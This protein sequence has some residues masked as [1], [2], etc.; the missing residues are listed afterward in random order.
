MSELKQL[1]KVIWNSRVVSQSP[2]IKPDGR[3]F[4]M[5]T[6][7]F[8][9]VLKEKL[10]DTKPIQ[11]LCEGKHISFKPVG[12]LSTKGLLS[13]DKQSIAYKDGLG[14]GVSLEVRV[15]QSHWKKLIKIDALPALAASDEYL[16][17]KF[18][19]ETDFAIPERENNKPRIKL[20]DNSC[21]EVAQA[22]DSSIP[23]QDKETGEVSENKITAKSFFKSEGGRLYFV[24]Q[25]PAAWLKSAVYPVYSDVDITYG[26]AS[27]FESGTTV[28]SACC[29]IDTNKFVVAFADVSDG[30]AG[31]ARVATVSGTTITWGTTSEFCSDVSIGFK[32]D[33]CKLDTDKFVVVY[34]DD[35]AGD[36]GFARV[37]TVATR[38]IS[39]GTAK[40]FETGDTEYPTCCQLGTDKF[41]V[42][43]D[44][45]TAGD[46]ATACVCTVSGTTIAAGTPVEW[47]VST[48]TYLYPSV[49]KLDTDKFVIAWKDGGDS[50]KMKVIVATVSGTVPSFGTEQDIDVDSCGNTSLAQ[51]D[52]D[53]F[54]L[55]WVNNTEGNVK[56]EIC[57]VSTTTVTEG[58]E[59]EL[60]ASAVWYVDVAYIDATHF[61]VVYE[62][63]GNSEKGTSRYCSFSGTT[64]TLGNEEVFHDAQTAY[65][66]ICLIGTGKVAVCYQDDADAS[67]IGEAI[68][69]D[70]PAASSP[71]VCTPTTLALSLTGKVPTIYLNKI[72]TP[73]KLAL[74]TTGYA[75][76]VSTPRLCTP[77][78]LALTLSF[79]VP[80]VDVTADKEVTPPALALTLTPHTPTVSTPR[81]CTPGKLSLV[82][83]LR[84]P[85]LGGGVVPGTLALTLTPHTPTVSTPRLCTPG[86]LALATSGKV[87]I[88]QLGVTP[89]AL[90]LV[91]TGYAP[92]V[93]LAVIPPALALTLTGHTPIIAHQIN[94]PTLALTLTFYAPDV[95]LTVV[96]AAALPYIIE[97]RNSSDEL[98]AIFQ[99]AHRIGL[100]EELNRPPMLDFLIPADDS[101]LTHISQSNRV[102]LRDYDT[103][104]VLYKFVLSRRRDSR[105]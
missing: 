24:K 75:P 1:E 28:Y 89:P 30:F 103:G 41:V 87:P 86:A 83:T 92:T 63:V 72:A 102:W 11:Y 66:S 46:N 6:M 52:T 56:I 36:D 20:G 68:I 50:S 55:A 45:E 76:T 99:N 105:D 33:V 23:T 81:L 54:V 62:D 9:A 61:V 94:V 18:E 93:G 74:S 47:T 104:T 91:L 16:E 10:T 58:A 79:H 27:E 21:I 88:I 29:E 44:E 77:T 71:V 101:K 34:A 85:I 13:T 82:L 97:A 42:V 19:V 64:I 37:G 32:V 15:S 4:L 59:V 96:L 98:L 70:C 90:P 48:S 51:L 25:I 35:V 65:V 69:G 78:T 12:G 38:T 57:T 5:D 8:H 95:I 49:C 100:T 26:T 60:D 39:W 73:S 53:K 14:A 3:D 67:D 84:T 2:D 43:Y 31:K 17:F 22:W 80:T 7:P 40:E